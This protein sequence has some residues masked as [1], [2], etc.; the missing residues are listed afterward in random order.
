MRRL[1]NIINMKPTYNTHL[2]L[3]PHKQQEWVKLVNPTQLR[4][5]HPDPRWDYLNW[6]SVELYEYDA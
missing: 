6:K 1:S 4:L 2:H 3:Y 5:F